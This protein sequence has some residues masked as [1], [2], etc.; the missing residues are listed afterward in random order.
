[1]GILYDCM[2]LVANKKGAKGVKDTEENRGQYDIEVTMRLG[3]YE[4]ELYD[5]APDFKQF[6]NTTRLIV[7]K[8]NVKLSGNVYECLVSWYNRTNTNDP[9][10]EMRKG[11]YTRILLELDTKLLTEDPKYVA[12]LM[13]DI[14]N[15]KRIKT[16]Y[17]PNG[18]K[19]ISQIELENRQTISRGTISTPPCGRYVGGVHG[20]ERNY[21]T[22]FNDE[23]GLEAHMLPEMVKIREKLREEEKTKR[24]IEMIARKKR[25]AELQEAIERYQDGR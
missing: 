3:G 1:M 25:I 11:N 19:E 5:S 20:P 24:K 9:N 17:I 12:V 7:S 21:E 8:K 22:Y 14:L 15:E 2:G 18:E 6:Y 16:R 23:I 10:E 4:V 13:N